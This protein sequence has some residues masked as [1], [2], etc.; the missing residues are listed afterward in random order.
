MKHRWIRIC[1]GALSVLLCA[2]C[3]LGVVLAATA[4]GTLPSLRYGILGRESNTEY[5]AVELY[6]YL[7]GTA[8]TD[9]EAAYL[10]TTKISFSYNSLIPTSLISTDYQAEEGT[11]SIRIRP[12][13]Y[14]AE[15]GTTVTWTPVSATVDGNTL[16]MAEEDG[17]YFGKLE[18]IFYSED[19][20]MKVDYAWSTEIPE[21]VVQ[22][23]R[24]SAY[25][26]GVEALA[27]QSAYDAEL[28][29]YNTALSEYNAWMRYVEKK[30]QYDAYIVKLNE[31]LAAKDAY[32]NYV[33][34]YDQYLIDVDVYN[35]WLAYD[36]A[37]F[38]FN[39][40]Y[41]AQHLAYQNYLKKF[42]NA[43]GKLELMSSLFRSDSHGW[44]MYAS[45]MGD[46]VASVVKHKDELIDYLQCSEEDVDLAGSATEKLRVLLGGYYN[47]IVAEY[48]SD[49]EKY[50]ARY[51][52][53]LKNYDALKLNFTDLYRTLNAL[54]QNDFVERVL[55]TEG[56][57]EHYL[58]FVGQ[59]YIIA[60]AFDEHGTR[61]P[62][63]KISHKKLTEV[64]EEIHLVPDGDWNPRNTA[65]PEKVA[66]PSNAG[67]P[68][69]PTS[70]RPTK[71][72]EEPEAVPHYGKRPE[73][74]P[75]P[76]KSGIP[77]KREEHPGTAPEAPVF[78]VLTSDLMREIR[79]GILTEYKGEISPV[80]LNFTSTV[81]RMVSINN[82]KTVNF[83]N[84]D[85]ALLH[86]ETVPYGSAVSYQPPKRENTP[87]YTYRYLGWLT[88]MDEKPDLSSIKE[89]LDLYAAY[90][91]TKCYYTVTWRLE[92]EDR[93]GDGLDDEYESLWGYGDLPIPG[94]EVPISS[95]DTMYY[96]YDFSGWAP[97]V[98]PVTGNVTYIGSM[99]RS[100]RKFPIKWVVCN[101]AESI[102]QYW[103]YSTT[104]TFDGN[105]EILPDDYRYTF[106]D[107]DRPIGP[108]TGAMTYTAVYDKV[109]LAMDGAQNVLHVTHGEDAIRIDLNEDNA[110][111]I[112]QVALLAA[113]Q[114]KALVLSLANGFVITIDAAQVPSFTALGCKHIAMMA[115]QNGEDTVWK[116][117]L[118]NDRWYEIDNKELKYTLQL[119]YVKQE[120]QETAFM[121]QGADG[122][123]RISG[124]YLETS[125]V[126]RVKSTHAYDVIASQNEFCNTM[127]LNRKMVAG[128]RV[129]LQLVCMPGYTVNGARVVAEDGTEI[130]V[131]DLSFIMPASTVTIDLVVERLEYKVTFLVEGAVWSEATYYYGD[132]IL[133]PEVPTL[134]E[135]DQHAYTFIGWGDVPAIAAGDVYELTFEASFVET[136]K[137]IDYDTGHN[138]NILAE[139]I[140]PCVLAGIVVLAAGI[141]VLIILRKR[142]K[143]KKRAHTMRY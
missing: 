69:P 70:S 91:V 48:P 142:A 101:G 26:K 68:I 137:D 86:T 28:A 72:P 60:T 139:V 38:A 67:R 124:K 107:W 17:V 99:V 58:Q 83:Y 79:K 129:S 56:K 6:E 71:L 18:D 95:Y 132:E 114:E 112:Y 2:C 45:I 136:K 81:E 44:Q 141:T 96:H 77:V 93:N 1:L 73:T 11:L 47:V 127:I 8:P 92:G 104:P 100:P 88:L 37:V 119:P 82:L 66:P 111:N 130:L 51:A 122:W 98:V 36:D 74:V 42:D 30:A 133:L 34:D 33:K 85:G 24:T 25:Q 49:H 29:A 15:N 117:G 102:E 105:V 4:K 23:L 115:E 128:E 35:Q 39:S 143:R 46:T 64:V 94:T 87:A 53:Y 113:Q 138:N 50:A 40:A 135:T 41:Q 121:L 27:V 63:W 20:E 80:T 84:Y 78:D 134:P 62:N 54:F 12:Y 10:N 120:T 75:N 14:E 13:V 118:Y 65:F 55:E 106:I 16:A 131:E 31:F 109:P 76:D 9:A 140:I 108:V 103:E 123:T 116:V 110:I 3:L 19:F 22:E 90:E 32:D 7:F 125:G 43:K 61:D 59:L 21:T 97:E 57:R 126:T 89:D 52:Y 5:S